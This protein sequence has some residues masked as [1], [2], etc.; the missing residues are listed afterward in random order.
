VSVVGA[1]D[2]VTITSL[3]FVPNVIPQPG[4]IATLHTGTFITV[5]PRPSRASAIEIL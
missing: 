2:S 5:S 4:S 1:L 3:A